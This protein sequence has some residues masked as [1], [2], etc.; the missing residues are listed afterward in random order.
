MVAPA[1]VKRVGRPK[2][3][4]PVKKIQYPIP[5]GGLDAVPDDF[6]SKV[7]KPFKRKDFAKECVYY[8][9]QADRCESMV[10][11]LEK[12]G[13]LFR[14]QSVILAQ[15]ANKEEQKKAQT[16]LRMQDKMASLREELEN[17]GIDVSMLD[18]LKEGVPETEDEN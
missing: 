13:K 16:M 11:K 12:R 18:A 2:G 1:K 17:A 15:F 7:N 5:E 6:D 9:L 14:R 10:I 3:K 8:A 4:G